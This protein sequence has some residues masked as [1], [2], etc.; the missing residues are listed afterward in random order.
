MDILI[1]GA[2]LMGRAIA[3]DLT[4]FSNFSKIT[5]IDNNKKNLELTKKFL[6]NHDLY[7]KKFDVNKYDELK[8]NFKKTDI[9]VSAL[10]YNFNYNLTKIAVDTKTHFIDLGGNNFIVKKQKTLNQLAKDEKVIIIP[11]CGLAP[12]LVSIITRDIVNYYDSVDYVK[13]RVGGLPINPI[14][15]FNYQFVF[16][17]DGLINEYFQDAIVLDNKKIVYKKSMTELEKLTFPKPFGDMEAF[18]TSGGCSILP[19]TFRYIIKYLDYKTI[20]YPGHCEKFKLLLDLGL[21]DNKP[22]KI[23]KLKINPRELLIKFLEKLIPING[24]DVVLLKVFSEGMKNNE[25]IKIEY[26]MID[27]FDKKNNITAMM[28]TTGYPVSIIA[29]MIEQ[30][31]IKKYG[32]YTPEEIINPKYFFKELE[33]RDIVIRKKI[34]KL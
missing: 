22:I 3:Y 24:E 4:I 11:D 15:P 18:I 20:R 7:F 2:G 33:K 14:P 13:L 32:V 10:P 16:S 8:K 26:T 6:K 34:K 31:I 17:P 30:R 1:L 12:G 9:I 29:Q 19:Y 23:N 21:G 5:I 25:K 27:Y 28:R